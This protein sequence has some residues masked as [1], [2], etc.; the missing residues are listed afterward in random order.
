[1]LAGNINSKRNSTK[2]VMMK[3]N[4]IRISFKSVALPFDVKNKNIE[5]EEGEEEENLYYVR[6]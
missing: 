6:V 1:M 4:P 2:L 3:N 5:K